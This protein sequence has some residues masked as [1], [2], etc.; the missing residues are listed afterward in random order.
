MQYAFFCKGIRSVKR[1]PEAGIIFENFCDKTNL[2][3][4]KVTFNCKL[5]K[6]CSSCS[7]IIMLPRFPRLCVFTSMAYIHRQTF[8]PGR[9]DGWTLYTN[10]Q[11]QHEILK[12]HIRQLGQQDRI[13][14]ASGSISSR[15]QGDH[16][17][18]TSAQLYT[19]PQANTTATTYGELTQKS[20]G[21]SGPRP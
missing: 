20:C 21:S 10:E 16:H 4:C 18:L 6:K 13:T 15:C 1:D 2:T 9:K 11:S 14:I 8:V 7:P 12:Q 3:V 19:I 17:P 5:Q